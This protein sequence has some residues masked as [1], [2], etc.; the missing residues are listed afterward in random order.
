MFKRPC[1][2][3]LA[4]E[5]HEYSKVWEKKA[6]PGLRNPDNYP[7]TWTAHYSCPGVEMIAWQSSTSHWDCEM[8]EM[9]ADSAIGL[10]LENGTAEETWT[11]IIPVDVG[12]RWVESSHRATVTRI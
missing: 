5:P 2:D 11:E 12:G 1:G 6:L 4:H 8:C 9:A 3:N 7:E 10:A